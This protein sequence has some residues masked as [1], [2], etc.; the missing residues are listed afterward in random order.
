[1]AEKIKFEWDG[2]QLRQTVEIVPQK[3]TPKEVVESISQSRNNIGQMEE[4]LIKLENNI[5]KLKNDIKAGKEHLSRLED[6]EPKCKEIMLEHLKSQIAK[7]ST[8]CKEQAIA[9]TEKT[10]KADPSAYTEDQKKNMNY[11]NYQRLLATDEKI[12]RKISADMI[13]ENIFM[14]PI[15]SNPF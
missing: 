3:F 10:I 4:N 6:F 13:R 7:C 14:N 2:E 11:V 12:A 1:M 8:K 15:Y 5:V 9:D